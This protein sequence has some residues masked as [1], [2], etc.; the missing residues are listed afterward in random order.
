MVQR[1]TLLIVWLF[2]LVLAV[3]A[4]ALSQEPEVPSK[5]DEARR[6]YLDAKKSEADSKKQAAESRKKERDIAA[7]LDTQ[8]TANVSAYDAWVRDATTLRDDTIKKYSE[9]AKI[10]LLP[11]ELIAAYKEERRIF[12]ILVEHAQYVDRD[13]LRGISDEIQDLQKQIQQARDDSDQKLA[14]IDKEIAQLDDRKKELDKR[15]SSVIAMPLDKKTMGEW[16]AAGAQAGHDELAT[17]DAEHAVTEAFD[18]YL[19]LMAQTTPPFLEAVSIS[20]AQPV[21][22]AVWTIHKPSGNTPVNQN[23]VDMM[24]ARLKDMLPAYEQGIAEMEAQLKDF[25]KE[26]SS[27]VEQMRYLPE[28]LMYYADAEYSAARNKILAEV[29]IESA[30]VIAEVALTGGTATVARKASEA[31]QKGGEVAA[32]KAGEKF[33]GKYEEM[34]VELG[35][36]AAKKAKAR[37]TQSAA[38]PVARLTLEEVIAKEDAEATKWIQRKIKGV[39]VK[40]QRNA[41]QE[42]RQHA[43]QAGLTGAAADRAAQKEAKEALSFLPRDVLVPT[44][45]VPAF[46][47][48]RKR[49]MDSFLTAQREEFEVLTEIREGTIATAS[50]KLGAGKIMVDFGGEK[51]MKEKK[52]PEWVAVVVSDTLEFGINRTVKYGQL[53]VQENILASAGKMGPT[54]TT[55]EQF[56]TGRKFVDGKVKLP[57]LREAYSPANTAGM[58]AIGTMLAK[59]AAVT[60]FSGKEDKA[61]DRYW[62]TYVELEQRYGEYDKINKATYSVW[63]ELQKERKARAEILA[64]LG[65][66]G[67]SRELRV[68]VNETASDPKSTLKVLL[69]FSTYLNRPPMVEL[70]GVRVEMTPTEEAESSKE[71]IGKVERR[72]LP[73]DAETAELRVW[74]GDGSKPFAYLDGDPKTAAYVNTADGRWTGYEAGFDTNHKILLKARKPVE[75]VEGLEEVG[76]TSPG[77]TSTDPYSPTAPSGW[78]HSDSIWKLDGQ[79]RL[80]SKQFEFTRGSTKG[81]DYIRGRL[82]VSPY[83]IVEK[84]AAELQCL[85]LTSGN[86]DLEPLENPFEVVIVESLSGLNQSELG[87][88]TVVSLSDFA[89]YVVAMRAVFDSGRAST[90]KAPVSEHLNVPVPANAKKLLRIELDF[91]ISG[92]TYTV[93]WAPD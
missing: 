26:L 19:Q 65:E 60:Y 72:D 52:A 71:W 58:I 45:N 54:S 8:L 23:Q 34:A 73:K 16:V 89:G 40:L 64:F 88:T 14:S 62:E 47:E 57:T 59:A 10:V 84:S 61:R 70:G 80:P 82:S 66:L 6:A 31:A 51:W 30:G 87:E 63:S 39:G 11:D 18:K 3:P 92:K 33:W 56:K 1:S 91:R 86:F 17:L 50:G 74:L 55:W 13:F 76:R 44:E 15:L 83:C 69:K 49:A 79:G 5:I 78:M 12:D 29:V 37:A 35:L 77:T 68:R 28:Y 90:M 2:G 22:S 41:T 48:A 46:Q 32:K 25:H 4:V 7:Q 24:R 67:R 21:Y 27:A 38:K 81:K 75:K 53:Q 36:E 93:A 43:L 20:A 42:A 9:R 85:S